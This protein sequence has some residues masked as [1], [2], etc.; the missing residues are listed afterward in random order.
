MLTTIILTIVL[1]HIFL[2]SLFIVRYFLV[3]CIRSSKSAVF[4]I[5]YQLYFIRMTVVMILKQQ[6]FFLYCPSFHTPR[7]TVLDNIRNIN[8]QILSHGEDQLIQTFL[9]GNP[10]C[11]LTF[12][13][14]ILN[15]TI[16]YLTSKERFKC[17]LFNQY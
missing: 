6:H 2:I 12:N 10:N 1:V 16:E 14:L 15:A 13:R 5:G 4:K 8:K 7:Q 17:P 9:Y 11:N 3:M